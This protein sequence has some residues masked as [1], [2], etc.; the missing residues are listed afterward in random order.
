ML[1]SE[2]EIWYMGP[3]IAIPRLSY[4]YNLALLPTKY[5]ISLNKKSAYWAVVIVLLIGGDLIFGIHGNHGYEAVF[6]DINSQFD[7][8]LYNAI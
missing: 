6:S 3:Y 5:F 8:L 4:G 7:K 1:V 2:L